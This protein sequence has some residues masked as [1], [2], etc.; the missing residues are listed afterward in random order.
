[1]E[2]TNLD[3]WKFTVT[4]KGM[5]MLGTSVTQTIAV[6]NPVESVTESQKCT[7]REQNVFKK[8]ET[9]LLKLCF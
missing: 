8:W 3:I 5:G 1:M 9:L 6:I 2:E 7:S 4:L